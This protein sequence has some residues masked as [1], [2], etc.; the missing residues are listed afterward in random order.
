MLFRSNLNQKY[1]D[2]ANQAIAYC[3][4]LKSIAIKYSGK[5]YGAHVYFRNPKGEDVTFYG[6]SNA[7]FVD[8]KD[9]RRSS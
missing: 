5:A 1:L 8:H 4:G 3:L 7:A 9:T 6:A 2:A